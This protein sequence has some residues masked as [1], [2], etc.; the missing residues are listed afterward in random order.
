MVI[1]STEKYRTREQGRKNFVKHIARA[2]KYGVET[3][4]SGSLEY[5]AC[6]EF[7]RQCPEG[8]DVDHIKALAEGG[9]NRLNNLR[10]LP[11]S[12]NRSLGG[13]MSKRTA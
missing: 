2:D 7:C 4:R 11:T 9:H 5:K 6:V 1:F 13:R 3:V 12:E 10:Y 8:F